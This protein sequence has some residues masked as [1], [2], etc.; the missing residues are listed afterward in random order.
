VASTTIFK[1]KNKGTY[2]KEDLQTMPSEEEKKQLPQASL[3]P[4]L[5]T[6][7]VLLPNTSYANMPKSNMQT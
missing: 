4:D 3:H 6:P 1:W 5:K 2:H 7:F